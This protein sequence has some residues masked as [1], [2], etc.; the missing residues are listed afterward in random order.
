MLKVRRHHGQKQQSAMQAKGAPLM[1]A[2]LDSTAQ[3]LAVKPSRDTTFGSSV[4]PFVGPW[5][6]KILRLGLTA[7]HCILKLLKS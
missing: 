5:R 3:V 6:F 4:A 2:A 7:E 1:K